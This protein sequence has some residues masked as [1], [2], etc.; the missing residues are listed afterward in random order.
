MVG[1]NTRT[2]GILCAGVK[3]QFFSCRKMESRTLGKKLRGHIWDSVPL[4]E[5]GNMGSTIRT[6]DLACDRVTAE[7]ET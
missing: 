4:H 2:H 1:R 5:R 7:Q 6:I 3:Y